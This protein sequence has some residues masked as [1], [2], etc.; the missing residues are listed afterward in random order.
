MKYVI[1]MSRYIEKFNI[2]SFCSSP[3]YQTLL[4]AC[5]R[6]KNPTVVY[7]FFFFKAIYN[8]FR[9]ALDLV[10]RGVFGFESKLLFRDKVH[11]NLIVRYFWMI[12]PVLVP[13][14]F[15]SHSSH[16]I[17]QINNIGL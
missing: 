15:I 14:G 8:Y 5:I 10:A 2:F 1:V 11:L 9:Y 16:E 13:L 4:K 3:L 17:K 12:I 6:S 7:W